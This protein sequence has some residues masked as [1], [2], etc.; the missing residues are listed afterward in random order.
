M[1]LSVNFKLRLNSNTDKTRPVKIYA[2]IRVDGQVA[3][4]F[5]TGVDVIPDRWDSKSQKIKGSS[6][7]IQQDNSTLENVRTD[8]KEIFNSLRLLN[9]PCNANIVRL[10]YL[11]GNEAVPTLLTT[12]Q[13]FLDK[14]EE[15]QGSIDGL[16][17]KTIDKWYSYKKHVQDFIENSLKRKDI[18]LSEF[19]QHLAEKYYRYLMS[20]KKHG[21][22]HAVKNLQNLSRVYNFA[23]SKSW[24]T[25]NPVDYMELK[26]DP[27]K[28]IFYLDETQLMILGKKEFTGTLAEVVDCFLFQCYTGMAYAE[29]SQFDQA[30]HLTDFRGEPIIRI[31]RFKQRK[32][33]PEACLIPLLPEAEALLKKHNG[34]LP[35]PDVHTMNRHLH[36]LE[37]ILKANFPIT[38]HIGR[39]TAGM[40][41]LNN[42]VPIETVSR[43]LGH[44]SISTTQKHYAKVLETRIMRDTAHLRSK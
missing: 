39:K 43:I 1:L 36:V 35:V 15:N 13:R 40:Y 10:K 19:T 24:T 23:K 25:A 12:Y 20:T 3:S 5:T 32:K 21:T 2:R 8:I 9:Q 17:Q 41:L 18:A 6:R 34:V 26:Q 42:N 38:S 31:F 30:K 28:P 22:N 29:L 16:E 44:S 37:P 11:K 33:N 14:L 7:E 4:D 27:P